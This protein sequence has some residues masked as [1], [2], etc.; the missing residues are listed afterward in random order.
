MSSISK[1]IRSFDNTERETITFNKPLT[2]IVGQNGSGKTTIIECLRYATTGDLPPHSKG[3]AFIHDPKI[4]GEK[5]VLGQ[6]K[7]AF[8]NVNGIQ[9]ICTRTMQVL[10]KKN[11]RQFKTLEGQLM[12][13]NNGE[14]TTVSTRCAELDAQMPLYL[15]V[16]KSILDYVIFCH[17]EE[18]LWPLSEPAVLKKRFDEI[19]EA[20]KFTKAL[21][22]I[23]SLRK[24]K[25][26]EIKL[27]TQTTE[28]LKADKD[29]ADKAAEKANLLLERIEDYK[30]QAD[31]LETKMEMVTKQ[32]DELFQSNQ[33]FQ[34][35]L[36]TSCRNRCLNSTRD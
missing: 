32:S 13:S 21:D 3:G 25:N 26:V 35:F 19:F 15:G 9:M 11:T 4:C 2:L 7:L 24:E 22:S 17:Q 18:S 12:A 30:S 36:M 34:Q 20:L 23:K 6:V 29:R 14:R 1:G 5:E 10:V 16:S 8:T 28:Y 31:E 33:Q 27:Q